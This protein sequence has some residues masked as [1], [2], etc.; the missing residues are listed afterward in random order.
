LFVEKGEMVER[1]DI[2]AS[3]DEEM[4]TLELHS[5]DQQLEQ[6]MKDLT[7]IQILA[8]HEAVTRRQLED[9]ELKVSLLQTD[10]AILKKQL[11]DKKIISPIS[12]TISERPA[13]TGTFITP[14]QLVAEVIDISKLKL[15]IDASAEDLLM[16][17]LGQ[18]VRIKPELYPDTD[19]RGEITFIS[20][21]PASDHKYPVEITILNRKP[22][23][24]FP[25]MFA[26]AILHSST[27]KKGIL[28]PRK[29]LSGTLKRPEVYIVRND[30]AIL[31]PVMLEDYNEEHLLVSHGLDD[32]EEV[33]IT[34]QFMIQDSSCVQVIKTENWE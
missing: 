16:V 27:M 18:Q 23:S 28:V 15:E 17:S 5:K 14:G 3:V 12:G 31:C 21:I 22:S 32:G 30:T 13:E 29:A 11:R 34:G 19:I 1:G 4:L 20:P 24:L 7:R 9:A 25:G 26:R 33:I 10:I 6:L 2:L 8:N